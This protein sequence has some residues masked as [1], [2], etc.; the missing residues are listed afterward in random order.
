MDGGPP[1]G[2]ADNR[3]RLARRTTEIADASL[4]I[5]DTGTLSVQ[6]LCG[7]ATRMVRHYGVVLIAADYLQLITP[8]LRGETREREVGEI[9]C[10]LK[11]LAPD[12]AVPVVVAALAVRQF[13]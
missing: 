3:A 8:E 1:E 6:A 7:E 11:A 5:N 10:R 2:P 12:L 4:Y 13:A 9:A